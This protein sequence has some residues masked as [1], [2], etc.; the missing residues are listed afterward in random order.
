MGGEASLREKARAAIQ[1]GRLPA[2]PPDRTWGG[3]G[4]GVICAVCTLPVRRDEIEFQIEFA[5]R[6]GEPGLE[7][8]H[9]HARCFAAWEL[10]R[11]VMSS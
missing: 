5:R 11:D 6:G 3:P 10:E 2:R 7:T 1:S 4:M 9:L 8:F